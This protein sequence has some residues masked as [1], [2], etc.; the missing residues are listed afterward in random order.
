MSYRNCIRDIAPGS[1]WV[2]P[3]GEL[4]AVSFAAA[5]HVLVRAGS[6]GGQVVISASRF[7]A[8]H[9]PAYP[10]ERIR[11]Q[12]SMS[13][14]NLSEFTAY[15]LPASKKLVCRSHNA[16]RRFTLPPDAVRIDDYRYPCPPECFFDDLNS[17][18]VRT[19]V[20]TQRAA[21]ADDRRA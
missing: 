13:L 10:R 6:R 16:R 11:S 2:G 8:T 9:Q 4:V 12:F 21:P 20:R 1:L 14:A 5:G 7:R 15:W 18:L 17:L 3:G 19:H